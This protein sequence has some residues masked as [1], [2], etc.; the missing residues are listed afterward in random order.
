MPPAHAAAGKNIKIAVLNEPFI[1]RS[2]A[3]FYYAMVC[4]VLTDLKLCRLCGACF[5]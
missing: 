2:A 1:K 3:N 4:T 5:G